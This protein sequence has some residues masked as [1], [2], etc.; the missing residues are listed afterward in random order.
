M[1]IEKQWLNNVALSRLIFTL[2]RLSSDSKDV[3]PN[4][5]GVVFSACKNNKLSSLGFFHDFRNDDAS[6]KYQT[7]K[8]YKF[9]NI[10][11]SPKSAQKTNSDHN[12]NVD[13][14]HSK[15]QNGCYKLTFVRVYSANA[16]YMKCTY[17]LLDFII[18]NETN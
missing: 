8:R 6:C 11:I 16:I 14:L 12:C 2:V 13:T 1:G 18:S 10:G 7:H 5:S 17:P 4:F 9:L 3:Y 15:C